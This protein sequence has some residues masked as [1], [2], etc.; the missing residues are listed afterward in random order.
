MQIIIDN[1][2]Y[3]AQEVEID[4]K[5]F[6]KKFLLYSNGNYCFAIYQRFNGTFH[7]HP[8]FGYDI[9]NIKIISNNSE[10]LY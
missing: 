10:T 1:K 3:I 6:M 4:N 7:V 2:A 5:N 9:T 8:M